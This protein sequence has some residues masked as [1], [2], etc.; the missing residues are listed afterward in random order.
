MAGFGHYRDEN[1]VALGVAHYT[2][3]ST[4]FH[5]GA[6]VGRGEHMYNAGVTWKVGSRSAEKAVPDKY[7]AGPIS[8]VYVLQDEVRALQEENK[9]L[10]D[11]AEKV[12]KDNRE[13]KE[14]IDLLMKAVG[15]SQ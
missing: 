11:H 4:M 9:A 15:L 7:R 5:I 2:N 14:K 6:S 12:E 1:A 10:R 13:M 3:E 8:S